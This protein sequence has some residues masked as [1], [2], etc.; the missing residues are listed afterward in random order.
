MNYKGFQKVDGYIKVNRERFYL[1]FVLDQV[2]SSSIKNQNDPCG[3]F[4]NSIVSNRLGQLGPFQDRTIYPLGNV[5]G[6]C[7]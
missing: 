5:K 3:G 1:C 7:I 2:V 6:L 4:V